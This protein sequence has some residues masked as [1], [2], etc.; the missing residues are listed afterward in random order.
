MKLTLNRADYRD[1]VL[2]C[3]LG[4]NIG[5]TVGMPFEWMRQVNDIDFY[6]EDRKG[7]PAPNDDLD[8][9][10]LWLIA[11]ERKGP[12][13]DSRTLADYWSHYL[14]PHWAEYGTAKANMKAGL[15]APM[16]GSLN[17]FYK[18]SCGAYIRSEIWACVAPGNPELAARYAYEDAILDHGDGE[19]TFAEIF[20]AALESAAFV[21]PE[22]R[23]LIQIGLSYIPTDCAV[24]K[25]VRMTEELHDAGKSWLEIRDAILQNYRGAP[26]PWHK[27]SDEDVAKGFG[28]GVLGYDVPANVA[29]TI[30]ALL[31]GGDD[32]GRIVC[33]AVNCGEDTDCTAATAGSIYG[34]MHGTRAIPQRWIDPIGRS[35]VTISLNLGD[36]QG[37]WVVPPNVDNLTD[38]T[39]KAM[40]SVVAAR[41]N[42]GLHIS[43]DPTDLSEANAEALK[44][45]AR[46]DVLERGLRGPIF[47]FDFYTVSVDYGDEAVIQSGVPKAIRVRVQNHHFQSNLAL[48][49]YLPEG[50]RISP[51]D[52]GTLFL[53]AG[54]TG[55]FEITITAD[56]VAESLSRGVLELAVPGTPTVMLVP[57]T[58]MRGDM[59]VMR[60]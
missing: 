18:H 14:V 57:I 51:S 28:D 39:V 16:C 10:L 52:V 40:D 30:L 48:R 53:F 15:P 8:I 22:L 56:R 37:G 60:S 29:L 32:F 43:D 23:Q 44:R 12:N 34:I 2:A 1:K 50:W 26:V 19:G 27:C 6:T 58:L 17:N 47:R 21:L 45:P 13:L 3:W 24:A 59:M 35:I 31:E 25:A 36:L 49:W 20:F 7:V 55:E 54:R 9:Q 38:R 5:G 41:G 46:F 33:T 4:K 11:L 42:G